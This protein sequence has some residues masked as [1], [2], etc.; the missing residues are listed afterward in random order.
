MTTLSLNTIPGEI[1]ERATTSPGPS[2]DSETQL[3]QLLYREI[4]F[5]TTLH[6]ALEEIGERFGLYEITSQSGPITAGCLATPAGI[7]AQ[8]ARIWL[9]AQ[10]AGNY[11]HRARGSD[12]YCLWCSWSPNNRRK[13]H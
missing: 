6:T 4:D 7:P 1:L 3:Q 2:L 10:A 5:S 13:T 11:L 9:E 8:S 12:L